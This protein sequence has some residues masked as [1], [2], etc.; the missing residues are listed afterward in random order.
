MNHESLRRVL[1][2]VGVSQFPQPNSAGWV[3]ISCVFAPWKHRGGN[4]RSRGMAIKVEDK[5]TSA[6]VCKACHMHGRISG[7][8]RGLAHY[9][10][11][12]YDDVAMEA[13]KYDMLGA[14]LLPFDEQ[15]NVVEELPEPLDEQVFAGMFEPI[16]RYPE[17]RLFMQS[18][19][20]TKPT[21]DK[22]KIEFDPE[23]RRIVFPVRNGE[24]AL[25][26]WSG[27]TTIPDYDGAKVLDYAGL[28][29]AALI[30]GE[31]RWRP[32]YPKLII[33][34]LFAYAR[35]HEIGAEEH[36]DIGALLGSTLTPQKAAILMAHG[37][38]VLAMP[39]PDK[40]GAQCLNGLY[41]DETGEFQGGGLIDQLAGEIPV[42]VPYYPQG[43]TDIDDITLDDL[44]RV[45]SSAP[46]VFPSKKSVDKKS[47]GF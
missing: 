38:T 17:A 3:H 37:C 32:G 4:D 12:D 16:G 9:R 14:E 6:Y 33:E 31:E 46:L 30:L 2:R 20:V 8:I 35:M 29:K 24:G 7:L 27:R 28:P 19:R 47:G 44:L 45:T 13:D 41:N 34:G 26:G 43:V 23:K 36:M 15:F 18:R 40:A 39:D 42:R 21:C 22:L 11:I 10:N 5:G 25:F 1:A